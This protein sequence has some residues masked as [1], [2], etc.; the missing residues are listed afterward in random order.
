MARYCDD[1]MGYSPT[2]SVR[3]S[4][5]DETIF[6]EDTLFYLAAEHSKADSGS[7]SDS[8]GETHGETNRKTHHVNYFRSKLYGGSYS[9]Y[10]NMKTQ[11]RDINVS[12]KDS[13]V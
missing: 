10:C 3:R 13:V 8:D 7:D 6:G 2:G 4:H 11:K 9:I 12:Q 1:S 5:I